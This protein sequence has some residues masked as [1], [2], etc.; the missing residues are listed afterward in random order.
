LIAGVW[1]SIRRERNG[2][3][4]WQI[5]AVTSLVAI[6]VYIFANG[7]ITGRAERLM[8]EAVERK[9]DLVPTLVVANPV[10]VQFWKREMLWRDRTHFGQGTFSAPSAVV[11]DDKVDVHQIEE[12]KTTALVKDDLDGAAYFFW[13]RMP[14][15]RFSGEGGKRQMDISDQRFGNP[16]VSDR[17]TVSVPLN[18]K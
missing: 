9:H 4:N 7:L 15:V 1:I 17:F 14:V 16:M 3:V 11:V 13:S 18:E 8:V 6:C 12:T 10:P 5:P 2:A